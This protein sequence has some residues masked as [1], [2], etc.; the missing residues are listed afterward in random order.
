MTPLERAAL[1]LRLEAEA[2]HG[3]QTHLLARD[4]DPMDLRLV[5]LGV[6]EAVAACLRLLEAL[7]HDLQL[8]LVEAWTRPAPVRRQPR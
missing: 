4:E 5:D 8:D 7:P 1:R 2:A 3:L 6:T